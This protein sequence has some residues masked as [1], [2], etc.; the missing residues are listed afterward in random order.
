MDKQNE[1]HPFIDY[2]IELK[3]KDDRGALA[4]LKRGLGKPPG[5]AARMHPYIVPWISEDRN[6]D[7]Y[8]LIGSLFALHPSHKENIDMGEAFRQIWLSYGK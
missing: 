5:T 6:S 8:Y 4:H 1:R 3:R 7:D 2:L